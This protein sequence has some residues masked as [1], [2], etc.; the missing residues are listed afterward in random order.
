ML[1]T[2]QY[3]LCSIMISFHPIFIAL[4]SCLDINHKAGTFGADYMPKGG[5]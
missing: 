1:G 4:M 5:T 3:L 2:I